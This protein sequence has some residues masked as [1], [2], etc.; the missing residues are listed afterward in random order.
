MPDIYQGNELWDYSL[1]DPDNRRPVDY[2]RRRQA[3][4]SLKGADPRELLE[5]W[6]DGRIKLFVTQAILHLRGRQAALFAQGRY[7]PLKLTGKFAKNAV[8]FMR[9]LEGD[10][11]LVVVPRATAS[12][13]FPPVGESW[14]DTALAFASTEDGSTWSD[15]LTGRKCGPAAAE[16]PLRE[17]FADF[18]FAVL[19]RER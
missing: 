7:R 6:G 13:G 17:V 19:A 12:V 8:A 2:A 5:N 16:W 9:E 15:L 11:L 10:A 18:P 3:L 1:V 14:Q 4:A